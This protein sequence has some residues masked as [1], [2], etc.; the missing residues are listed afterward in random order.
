MSE[1]CN[2]WDIALELLPLFIDQKTGQESNLFL[3]RHLAE[4]KECQK[5]YQLMIADY[6]DQVSDSQSALSNPKKEKKKFFFSR[7][8]IWILAA[9]LIGYALLM[10]GIVVGTFIYLMGI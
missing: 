10:F 6:T 8:K 4:C 1:N 7:K 3:A 9:G 2:A 5:A